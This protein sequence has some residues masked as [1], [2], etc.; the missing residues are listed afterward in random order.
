MIQL[1]SIVVYPVKSCRGIALEASAFGPDGLAHDR[2]FLVVDAEGRFLTQRTVHRLALV[3]TALTGEALMLRAP[4]L[5]ELSVPLQPLPHGTA[6]ERPVTIWRDTV[7]AEDAG[8]AAA[9]WFTRVLGQPC[10]LVRRGT[11]YHRFLPAGRIPA[12]ARAALTEVPVSFADA[13]PMLVLSEESLADLNGRLDDPLPM[14]R[15]RP[16][17]ILRGCA[18]PFAEDTWAAFRVGG[19]AVLHAGGPCVRCIMPTIDQETAT[20][21]GKEPLCTLALYRRERTGDSTGVI[22][23]QNVMP[24]GSGHL[25][26][27]DA[28]EIIAA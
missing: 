22:F 16:N 24:E 28:V 8:D 4:D 23:G 5:E 12:P 17:L 6:A 2:E 14:N 1:A 27:G 25:R 19:G 26:V 18:A 21:Q 20:P 3:E 13:F 15:F 11:A 7:Q 9:D 10:R